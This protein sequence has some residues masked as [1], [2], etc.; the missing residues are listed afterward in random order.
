MRINKGVNLIN[1]IIILAIF[2]IISFFVLYPLVYVVSAAFS[3]GSSIASLSMVPFGDGFKT[4]HF[5]RLF[6]ERKSLG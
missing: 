2:I 5:V 1:K 4:K 3:P 6:T